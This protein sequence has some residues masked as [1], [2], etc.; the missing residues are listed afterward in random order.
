MSTMTIARIQTNTKDHIIASIVEDLVSRAC[1]E[2]DIISKKNKE[3]RFA[4]DMQIY[5]YDRQQGPTNMT[6]GE[7][8]LTKTHDGMEFA[9]QVTEYLVYAYFEKRIVTFGRMIN[10]ILNGKFGNLDKVI[11]DRVVELLKNAHERVKQLPIYSG[12]AQLFQDTSGKYG[13]AFRKTHRDS[14]KLLVNLCKL[15]FRKNTN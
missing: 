2:N 7:D 13:L 14:L 10:P 1:W 11:T 12:K 8:G 15:S 5:Y 6:Q 4:E 3:V 9:K